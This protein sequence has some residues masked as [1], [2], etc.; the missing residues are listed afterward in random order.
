MRD[1]SEILREQKME[2]M[3]NESEWPEWTYR[4]IK[5]NPPECAAHNLC[6]S[7]RLCG[8]PRTRWHDGII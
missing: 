3:L 4:A 6:R 8:R 1:W 2:V 5:W 7:K